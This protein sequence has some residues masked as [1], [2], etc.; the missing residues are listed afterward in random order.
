M[1]K[2][3]VTDAN[4]TKWFNYLAGVIKENGVGSEIT[5]ITIESSDNTSTSI[6]DIANIDILYLQFN[7]SSS[8]NTYKGCNL[9]DKDHMSVRRCDLDDNGNVIEDLTKIVIGPPT[10][11]KRVSVSSDTRYVFKL[12]KTLF[13]KAITYHYDSDTNTYQM[14]RTFDNVNQLSIPVPFQDDEN[15]ISIVYNPNKGEL[16]NYDET[17]IANSF[18]YGVYTNFSNDY[19]PYTGGKPSP[20]FEYP[21]YVNFTNIIDFTIKDVNSS[22]KQNLAYVLLNP[23]FNNDTINTQTNTIT[24]NYKT[25]RIDDSFVDNEYHGP[26]TS[27]NGN[28]NY[29]AILIND[30]GTF[31]TTSKVAYCDS[32]RFNSTE[33]YNEENFSITNSNGVQGKSTQFMI[34]FDKNRG[35]D[36]LDKVKAFLKENPIVIHYKAI[37]PETVDISEEEGLLEKIKALHLYKPTSYIKTNVNTM[38]VYRK[39]K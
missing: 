30:G 18:M 29:I 2:P 7:A 12:D 26:F 13:E 22:N 37:T 20:S 24:R 28:T 5:G 11:G 33:N 31:N 32:L 8:Q 39:K 17:K 36:T 23:L 6:R 3:P 15:C 27:G 14:I 25:V 10:Y 38:L 35:L 9:F 34:M 19:E 21:Q 4:I 16:S 1:N